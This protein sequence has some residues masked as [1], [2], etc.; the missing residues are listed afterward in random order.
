MTELLAAGREADAELHNLC[1][2][3]KDNSGMGSLY[4]S[5]HELVFVFKTGNGTHRNNVQLGRFGRNRSNVWRYP[6]VN[7]FSR[8]TEEGNLLALHPTVKPVALVADA[9]L[10]CT[11]R[12]DIVLDGFLGRGT[13]V[14][15]AER[16]GRRCFGTELDPAYVDTIIRRW[17]KLTG[18]VARHAASGRTLRPRARGGGGRCRVNPITRL[19]TRSRP[20]TASSNR[21]SRATPR[22]RPRGAKNMATLLGEALDEKVTLTDNGRR[23]SKREIIVTQLVNRS[24]LAD[25]KAMQIPLGMVQEIERRTGASNEPTSLSEADRQV[26]QFIRNRRLGDQTGDTDVGP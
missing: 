19:A 7:S 9:I 2:W 22:G 21:D 26:L 24:A 17:Q 11:A 4:R 1:I 14:I 16:T 13:T 3:V 18:E 12:S 15:A 10:D 20:S 23:V 25:P 5:Q 6:G 8:K